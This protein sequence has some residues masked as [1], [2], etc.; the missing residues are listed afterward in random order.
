MRQA[1]QCVGRVIRSKTDYGF[2]YCTLLA[3]RYIRF[4]GRIVI[5]AD[6][7]FY[8]SDKRSKFPPWITAFIRETTCLN[9]STDI[10]VE[11]VFDGPELCAMKMLMEKRS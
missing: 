3:A 10:A 11:Q 8:K 5:L 9:L 2:V 4:F 6:A 7:R 1:A